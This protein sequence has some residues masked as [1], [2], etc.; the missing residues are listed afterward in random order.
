MTS[1]YNVLY[2]PAWW[3]CSFFKEQQEALA[4]TFN[5]IIL[6]GKCHHFSRRFYLKHFF[7]KDLRTA[8]GWEE[9]G[10]LHFDFNWV[11]VESRRANNQLSRLV[12]EVGSFLNNVISGKRIDLVYI[13]SVSDLSV[14]VARWA[15]QYGIPVILAEHILFIRRN[16]D[17]LSRQKEKLFSEVN[18]VFCVSNHLYRNLLTSGLTP[19]SVELVGNLVD[20]K[21]ESY[22]TNYDKN[23]KVLFVASHLADKDFDTF[24]RTVQLLP[25]YIHVDVVGL[26]NDA[27]YEKE[28]SLHDIV[29]ELGLADQISFL[30]KMSHEDLIRLY[31]SYSVLLST[32]RSETFGLSVAEALSCGTFAVC[33]DSGGIHDFMTEKDGVIVDIGDARALANAIVEAIKDGKRATGDMVKAKFAKGPYVKRIMNVF[34][35]LVQVYS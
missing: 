4:D 35:D 29:A 17:F 27:L 9:D 22:K 15:R 1:F 2:L 28:R 10:L 16:T 6:I 12:Q 23:G 34:M 13:Q 19:R 33:T 5:P 3:P 30:G 26:D 11:N 14:I 20:T 31:A 25:D 7:K 21:C 24:L 18:S 32:S 8:H